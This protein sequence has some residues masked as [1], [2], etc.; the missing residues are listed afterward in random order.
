V[1]LSFYFWFFVICAG[2]KSAAAAHAANDAKEIAAV[3]ENE[4]TKK[5][6]CLLVKNIGVT[7]G[8]HL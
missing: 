5:H 1:F 2:I 3:L 7:D 8:H 6:H 4:D